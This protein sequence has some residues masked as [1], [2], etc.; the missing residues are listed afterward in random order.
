MDRSNYGRIVSLIE[1]DSIFFNEFTCGL[2]HVRLYLAVALDQF[3]NY[4]IGS[5]MHVA[6]WRYATFNDLMR[7][8]DRKH[9]VKWC[10][11]DL[12]DVWDL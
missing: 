9:L 3:A 6:V 5:F 11:L 12:V 1:C 7:W 2:A 4:G 8:I 10:P